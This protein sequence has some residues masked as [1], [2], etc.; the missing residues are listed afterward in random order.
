MG[1]ISVEPLHL[2][3]PSTGTRHSGAL[4]D[5]DRQQKMRDNHILED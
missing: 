4:T 2:T 1:G 3:K 5:A